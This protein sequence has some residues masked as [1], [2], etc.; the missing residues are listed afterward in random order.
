MNAAAAETARATLLLIEDNPDDAFM[1]G[2]AMR[3]TGPAVRMRVCS[4]GVSGLAFLRDCINDGSA[5]PD[6]IL[7]DLNM[8]GMSGFETL[9]EIRQNPRTRTIPVVILSTS[10]RA[11]DIARS[12]D[13]GA[14]SYV[15]KPSTFPE[16]ENFCAALLVYWFN[17]NRLP[18]LE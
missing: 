5:L 12:Y 18:V 3:R 15:V 7:L 4:D 8:P 17:I 9:V 14:S 2:R 16:L 13:A 6:L 11:E 1:I 10:D